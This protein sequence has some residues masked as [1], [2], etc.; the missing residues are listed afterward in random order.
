MEYGAFSHKGLQRKSN[1]DYF[2][3]PDNSHDRPAIMIIA[4]G[5]GGHKAGECASKLA[6]EH[7]AAYF[8]K[9]RDSLQYTE[10]L[11]QAIQHSIEQANEQ[12]LDL[13]RSEERFSGMGTTLTMVVFEKDRFHV[14]H[15]GDSRC[16][17]IRDGLVRQITRDHSLVQELLDHGSITKD[18]MDIH[19]KKNVITRALGTEDK[20]R[21]DCFEEILQ[22]GDIVLLC[23]DGLINYID[24]EKYA[25]DLPKNVSMAQLAEMLGKEALAAGGSDD[26]TITAARYTGF[27]KRGD[28]LAG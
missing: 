16:Y 9:N 21:I 27:E 15:I 2:Y 13:S 6:V 25:A 5:M 4:D 1:E 7:V 8:E 22:A 18:E 28:D 23:T 10:E 12:V 11:I 14:A 26:I 24:L 17:L 20:L 19:P 3:I